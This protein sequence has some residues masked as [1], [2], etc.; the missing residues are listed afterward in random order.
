MAVKNNRR[1]QMTRLLLRTALIE[2]MQEK[3]FNEITIKEI[4]EQAFVYVDDYLKGNRDIMTTYTAVLA[5]YT[6]W[7]GLDIETTKYTVTRNF[8]AKMMMKNVL[9]SLS[10]QASGEDAR[11]AILR[12]RNELAD[13]AGL[14]KLKTK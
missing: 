10:R 7:D 1:A 12:Q 13:I 11:A 2:L 4:C 14:P 3:P 8:Q 9:E 6:Y 5:L